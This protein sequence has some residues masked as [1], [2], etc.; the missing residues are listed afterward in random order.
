MATYTKTHKEKKEFDN[1]LL[2]LKSRGANYSVK[3]MTITYSFDDEKDVYGDKLNVWH[4]TSFEKGDKD[5]FAY[6]TKK[7][8]VMYGKDLEEGGF[9]SAYTTE[10]HYMEFAPQKSF[11]HKSMKEAKTKALEHLKKFK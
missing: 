11:K 1:H 3:V 6:S 10:K 9:F 2:L 8:T 5:S 7:G 4:D